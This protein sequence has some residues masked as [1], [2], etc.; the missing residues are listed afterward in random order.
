[1]EPPP[2]ITRFSLSTALV[3]NAINSSIDAAR[4]RHDTLGSMTAGA[5]TGALYKSTGNEFTS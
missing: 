1:M 3:Y 2:E 5:L 4:G